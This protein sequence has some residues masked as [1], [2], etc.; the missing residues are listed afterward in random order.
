[1]VRSLRNYGSHEKYKNLVQGPNDRLDELQ[2]A[3]LRVK[4]KHIDADNARRREILEQR[5]TEAARADDKHPRILQ[6]VL[7]GSANLAHDDVARVALHLRFR[8]R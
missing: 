5:R 4:L 3:L 6:P 2:A 8:K 7:A 1:M